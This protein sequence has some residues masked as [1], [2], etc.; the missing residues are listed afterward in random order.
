VPIL[1]TYT[2]D[3]F[4]TNTVMHVCDLFIDL[5]PYWSTDCRSQIH[6]TDLFV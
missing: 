1:T 6:V 5:L 3:Q 2:S 4:R